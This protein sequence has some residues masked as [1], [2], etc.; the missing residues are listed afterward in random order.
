MVMLLL[1]KPAVHLPVFQH[2]ALNY[3]TL[4]EASAS[5]K[6]QRVA[7][8]YCVWCDSISKQESREPVFYR[9]FRLALV[10]GHYL[11]AECLLQYLH[12]TFCSA[13]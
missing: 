1:P 4:H 11:F 12:R 3:V 7:T 8:G 13:V 2:L 6:A 9:Q 10:M 5:E